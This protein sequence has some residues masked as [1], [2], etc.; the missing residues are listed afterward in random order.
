MPKQ[1]NR[2]GFS[3]SLYIVKIRA[4]HAVEIFRVS[5]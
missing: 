5:R 1:L 3:Q 2:L 4:K